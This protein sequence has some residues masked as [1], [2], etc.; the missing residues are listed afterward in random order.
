M[1][2]HGLEDASVA[3]L[4]GTGVLFGVIHVMTG[5]DHLSALATLSA[6]SSWRSFALGMRWGMGHSIGL[7]LMAVFFILL[8]GKLNLDK[9]TIVTDVIVGV[10]MVALGGYGL[11][12]G[13]KKYLATLAELDTTNTTSAK[14]RSYEK[15]PDVDSSSDSEADLKEIHLA[16][17]GTTSED[18]ATI[19]SSTGS[20]TVPDIDDE[21]EELDLDEIEGALEAQLEEQSA[22]VHSPAPVCGRRSCLPTINMDNPATQKVT[23]LCVGIVHGIAGPGGI[24]GVLPA[25]GLHNW[26]KSIAYLGSF[27]VTS[28]LIMGLFAA[29]YGE[30]TAQLGRR[31]ARIAYGIAVFSSMLSVLVGILWIVLVATGK[32]QDVFGA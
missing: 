23:A 14:T 26:T 17:I 3:G 16:P 11:Y 32:L 27:C 21:M 5:P 12:S 4:V 13:H 6:G 22:L 10:F 19:A 15:C 28:I 7:I 31:S 30:A 20:P 25:V 2:P 24:L 29:F 9:L 18:E 1:T 8:D